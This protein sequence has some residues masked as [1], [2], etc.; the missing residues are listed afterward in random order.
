MHSPSLALAC[1]DCNS[2]AVLGMTCVL[3]HRDWSKPIRRCSEN[4]SNESLFIILS[5]TRVCQT[6]WQDYLLETL[7][8]LLLATRQ[9]ACNPVCQTEYGICACAIYEACTMVV[10]IRRLSDPEESSVHPPPP[11]PPPSLQNQGSTDLKAYWASFSPLMHSSDALT[12]LPVC[13]W[14]ST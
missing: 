9:L 13:S 10:I 14:C 6:L 3:G 11:P 4:A 8:N 2:A 7:Q 12:G 5:Q 1:C